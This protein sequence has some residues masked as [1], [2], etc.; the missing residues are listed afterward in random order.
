MDI[1]FVSAIVGQTIS[2]PCRPY[3]P[4]SPVSWSFCGKSSNCSKNISI[5]G[6][7]DW[8]LADKYSLGTGK[9]RYHQLIIVRVNSYDAGL[10][11]CLEASAGGRVQQLVLEISSILTLE[12]QYPLVFFKIIKFLSWC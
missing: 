9:D 8:H 5:N 3:T 6:I 2:L 7:V 4:S 1:E 11:R 10:Y 12:F